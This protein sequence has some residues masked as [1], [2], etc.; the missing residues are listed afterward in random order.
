M[1][2]GNL[3]GQ[4]SHVPIVI[5]DMDSPVHTRLLKKVSKCRI[6]V[7]S[8]EEDTPYA[9]TD[10][11]R[12]MG[13]PC[14]PA[15][16]ETYRNTSSS[17]EKKEICAQTKK[18][19]TTSACSTITQA[20]QS[21]SPAQTHRETDGER[22]VDDRQCATPTQHTVSDG[23]AAGQASA[24]PAKNIQAEQAP[25]SHS[26]DSTANHNDAKASQQE[27]EVILLMTHSE[28]I[29]WNLGH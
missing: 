2:R 28:E 16:C 21:V 23:D 5:A 29:P 11:V 22:S 12:D 20:K 15:E 18:R 13:T 8:H 1:D 27:S 10:K 17:T 25:V 3:G 19:K 14:G 26:L 24:A 6:L 9:W 4:G 7:S